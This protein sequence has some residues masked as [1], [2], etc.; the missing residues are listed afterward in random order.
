MNKRKGPSYQST[1]VA[2]DWQWFEYPGKLG[3]FGIINPQKRTVAKCCPAEGWFRH[4]YGRNPEQEA[5]AYTIA[6]I[7]CHCPE[8]VRIEKQEELA[9]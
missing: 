2:P 4:L 8:S 6:L 9:A 1:E 7:D 5:I 3:T